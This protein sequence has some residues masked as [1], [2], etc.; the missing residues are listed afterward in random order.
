MHVKVDQI[1]NWS[2]NRLF[3]KVDGLTY[4]RWKHC[5][6]SCPHSKICKCQ[7]K[8][9]LA[10]FSISKRSPSSTTKNNFWLTSKLHQER[11][12]GLCSSSG[13]GWLGNGHP[14]QYNM[15]FDTKQ[16]KGEKHGENHWPPIDK[17]CLFLTRSI[18]LLQSSF[19]GCTYF[20][21][22]RSI[23]PSATSRCH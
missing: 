22:I 5:K 12:I 9:N 6:S 18:H 11:M 20:V 13:K 2:T 1:A 16:Q 21:L 10:D 17:W 8:A 3:G 7:G 19:Y 15:T 14:G 4:I 23:S